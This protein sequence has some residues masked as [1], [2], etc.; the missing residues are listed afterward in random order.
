VTDDRSDHRDT[1]LFVALVLGGIVVFAVAIAIGAVLDAPPGSLAEWIAAVSTFAALLAASYA[2]IQTSRTFKL[3]Q[4]RD[5]QRDEA[6]RQRQAE[7]VAA[8]IPDAIRHEGPMVTDSFVGDSHTRTVEEGV[9]VP[10]I[11]PVALRNASDLPVHSFTVE[12]YVGDSR[13]ETPVLGGRWDF[14]PAFLGTHE[15]SNIIS[16]AL[17]ESLTRVIEQRPGAADGPS[18]ISIGWSFA[19]NAGVRWRKVPGRPLE[20]IKHA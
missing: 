13:T 4:K 9:V 1:R 7:L 14:G 19:D 11:L 10:T 16:A 17:T 15:K 3:E 12:V 20:E 5:L 2:A 8:W 6:L 18:P